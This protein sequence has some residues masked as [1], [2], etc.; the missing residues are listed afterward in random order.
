MPS[1]IKN[2][3]DLPFSYNDPSPSELQQQHLRMEITHAR[4][5]IE[6]I[7]EMVTQLSAAVNSQAA[8]L[9]AANLLMQQSQAAMRDHCIASL[10]Y[11]GD[12]TNCRLSTPS[13]LSRTREARGTSG[14][15]GGRIDVLHLH[16]SWSEGRPPDMDMTLA[17]R[18]K[19]AVGSLLPSSRS[20]TRD[21]SEIEVI[22]RLSTREVRNEVSNHAGGGV[23]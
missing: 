13:P 4:K 8:S 22:A 11:R 21:G 9:S 18:L 19:A 2:T 12:S 3:T 16:R 1:G 20:L 23:D 10:G 14:P 17:Q 15:G 7:K 5:E 6:N